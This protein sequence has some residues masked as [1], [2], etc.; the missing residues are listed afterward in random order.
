MAQ[1]EVHQPD[2]V[3]RGTIDEVLSHRHEIPAD[4]TVELRV[5]TEASAV[6]SDPTIALLES[7]LATAPTEPEAIREAE[8][9]L[10]EFKRNMNIPRKEAG[11]RLLYPEVE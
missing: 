10:R 7:W 9:D 4:A 11:A 3:Y 8:E 2:L 5:F 6:E 1:L